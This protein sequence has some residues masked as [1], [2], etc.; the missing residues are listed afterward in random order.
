MNLCNFQWDCGDWL[1]HIKHGIG[2]YI[3]MKIVNVEE[4]QYE[5]VGMKFNDDKTIWIPTPL[6]SDI[7]YYAH[8]SK[9]IKNGRTV[10]KRINEFKQNTKMYSEFFIE[11]ERIRLK[12]RTEPMKI[13]PYERYHVELTQDQD[14]CLDEICE[15]LRSGL[16]MDRLICG[17]VCTGKTEIAMQISRIV[18]HNDGQVVLLVPTTL[19]ARQHYESFKQRFA[20]VEIACVTRVTENLNEI[21]EKCKNGDIKIIITTHSV[22]RNANWVWKNLKL[23]IVDEEHCFGTQDKEK[24][25]FIN[26]HHLSMSASPLPRTVEMVLNGSKKVSLLESMPANKKIAE[27]RVL[28][29]IDISSLVKKSGQVL[30]VCRKIKDLELWKRTIQDQLN[31]RKIEAPIFVA[32]GK[33]DP[34]DV[35]QILEDYINT[36]GAILISTAL[37][38]VGLDKESIHTLVVFDAHYWGMSQLHQLRG[39]VSRSINQGIAYFIAPKNVESNRLDLLLKHRGPGAG[40]ILAQKD[41]EIRGS[42]S[43][44]GAQQSGHVLNIGL[45]LLNSLINGIKKRSTLI[46][47]V[48]IRRTIPFQYIPN[49]EDRLYWY[50]CLSQS[51]SFTELERLKDKMRAQYGCISDQMQEY[52]RIIELKFVAHNLKISSITNY[53]ADQVRII[54]NNDAQRMVSQKIATI[55][56]LEKLLNEESE[57]DCTSLKSVAAH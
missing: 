35:Q 16:L 29:Y 6:L 49:A 48:N 9:I 52:L 1:V 39:R 22:V 14:R 13:I 10:L 45:D 44:I 20:D 26:S 55:H 11:Q 18:L 54:Y 8:S 31:A 50:K 30:C 56:D 43:L 12:S 36:D 46:D 32:H 23:T 51:N 34:N 19:L 47:I 38:G 24:I 27:T 2:R 3:G 15:D 7:G 28:D 53:G 21:I 33:M 40:W 41:M 42:G 57:R 4:F 17:D 37:V 5:C 25:K